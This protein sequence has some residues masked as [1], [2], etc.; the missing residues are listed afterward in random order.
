MYV[1]VYKQVQS[2][3]EYE[4][5]RLFPYDVDGLFKALDRMAGDS[6]SVCNTE[7]FAQAL[8]KNGN[9]VYR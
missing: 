7:Q 6:D 8:S 4:Y 1:V 2:L 9:N 3:I 5:K